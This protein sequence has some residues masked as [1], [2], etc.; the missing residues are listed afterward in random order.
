MSGEEA[1]KSQE[2]CELR[3][4]FWFLISRD[5]AILRFPTSVQTECPGLLSKDP[6]PEDPRMV[7]EGPE[8]L[9][10]RGYWPGSQWALNRS[11]KARDRF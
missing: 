7:S 9:S 1:R 8:L 10:D 4:G 2:V 5:S 11:Q 3:G 6:K